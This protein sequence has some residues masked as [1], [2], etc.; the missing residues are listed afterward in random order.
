MFS[1]NFF[2]LV[3][4]GS[5]PFHHD[6]Y[7]LTYKKIMKVDYYMPP[8]VSKAASHLI[9]QLLIVDPNKRMPLEQVASHPWFSVNLK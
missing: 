9:A 8:F 6:D 3:L 2:F 7:D 1:N 5:A 4:V